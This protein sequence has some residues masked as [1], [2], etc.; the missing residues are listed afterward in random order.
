ML[1]RR[2]LIR[3]GA[4][5]ALVLPLAALAAFPTSVQAVNVHASSRAV[6][7][8]APLGYAHCHAMVVT[9]SHGTPSTSTS[10]TGLSPGTID[11]VYGF[12]GATSNTVGAGKT[13][14]LVDAYD[15]PTAASDLNTFST[16][17]G[18]PACTTAN[19]C[20]SKVNQTGGSTYPQANSGWALEISLDI[21]WAH[22]VA[23]GAKILLV[24]ASSNSFTNLMAAEDY[25]SAHATYVSNSWGGGESSGESAYDSH[26]THS[27]VS[28]FV[29]AGDSGLPAEYPSSSPDV[30]SVGGT[31]LTF[32]AD[33]SVTETG[34]SSGGGGCSAYENATSAQSGFSTYGQVN[35]GGKRATPD[36]AL[37]A[38]PNSGVAVYDSTSYYG[39]SGWFTVGGTSASTPMW[40]A[41]SAD[42]GVVVN[43]AYVYGGSINFRD[44]I[45]GGNSAG[46][47]VGFD[48]CSGRGSWIYSTSSGTT[49]TT[50]TTTTIAGTTTT[51]TSTTT[52]TT[53]PPGGTMSVSVN[54]GAS[55]NKGPNYK[56]P[57]SVSATD[58][59]GTGPISGAGVTLQVFQGSTCSGKLAATGTGTT[60]ST[61]VVNFTFST[62]TTGAWCAL[63]TVT[64]TNYATGTGSTLFST[65]NP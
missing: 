41:A 27:G 64:A 47:L 43:S 23:P 12:P 57:L 62:K 25:A 45:A 49:T 28:Y 4:T 5:A 9:D 55:T 36:V 44:I 10:P 50:S 34:W 63:A 8:G 56:V 60:A 42:K 2:I 53:A 65:P 30:I 16:Q 32:N 58:A 26:F 31:T 14:A 61:G 38:D 22:A 46:C 19:G 39:Q 11:S 52:T 21:E 18:L 24:E 6:C 37:D 17:F 35:C 54:A 15:D 1:R 20:F 48:L 33:G 13:I 7:P 59:S 3:L 51:S 40:A 29:A